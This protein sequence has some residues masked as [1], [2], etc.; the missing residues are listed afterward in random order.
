MELEQLVRQWQL[1]SARD[2]DAIRR[3]WPHGKDR[4]R[5]WAFIGLMW[6]D[7]KDDKD[8]LLEWFARPRPWDR[9]P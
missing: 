7:V 3:C 5:Q 8:D 1:D 2:Q 4:H 6:D 9:E